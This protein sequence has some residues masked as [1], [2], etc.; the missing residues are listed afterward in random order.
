M[1]NIFFLLL[2]VL[3]AA[4]NICGQSKTVAVIPAEGE[5]VTKDIRIGVTNGLQEGVFN[6]GR[7]TLLARGKAFDKA[8]SE[9]KFQQSGAV[10]D[11][12]LKEFGHA[13]GA[14]YV[15][16]ATLSKY[17]ETSFRISYKMIDVATGEIVNMGSETVRNGVD[18]LLT[19]TDD[20]AKK[21]FG[22]RNSSANISNNGNQ[23]S[24]T[25]KNNS[26]VYNRTYNNGDVYNPDGIKLVYVEGNNSGIGAINGFFIGMYEVTQAQWQTVMGSNPSI[27]KGDSNLPVEFVSWN[28]AQAFISKINALTGRHYRLPTVAEWEFAAHGGTADK[29][30]PGS[31]CQ[32]S[33]SNNINSVAWYSGNSGGKT[34]EVGSKL[35]N[36]LGIY[37]MTGNVWEWCEDWSDSSQKSRVY[38]GGGWFSN[39]DNCKITYH[40]GFAPD[41]RNNYI[42]FRVAL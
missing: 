19:A 25:I 11:D 38:C 41:A 8:L 35:P 16:Y 17:S 1:K 14:D 4:A 34:Q 24:S 18:G 31:G 33:G 22:N 21:I 40:N 36:E 9:M 13:S 28:D 3:L 29:V 26:N 32:Y 20:I 7:Y 5:S 37:D 27:F 42:G 12:Q 6:S 23:S 15:C 10:S 30:C 39:E 2:A